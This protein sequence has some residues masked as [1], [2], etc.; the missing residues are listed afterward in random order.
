MGESSVG[1][2]GVSISNTGS[3]GAVAHWYPTVQSRMR[4]NTRNAP[5][6]PGCLCPVPVKTWCDTA[7]WRRAE[8]SALLEAGWVAREAV[9]CAPSPGPA[10]HWE[11]LRGGPKTCAQLGVTAPSPFS[12]TGDLTALWYR[13][14]LFK[15]C[16]LG[17]FPAMEEL[18]GGPQL[19]VPR[20]FSSHRTRGALPRMQRTHLPSRPSRRSAPPSQSCSLPAMSACALTPPTGTAVSTQ[21]GS[22]GAAVQAPS[23]S[24]TFP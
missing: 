3:S 18:V 23:H 8:S 16:F 11:L 6:K 14:S 22:W 17:R 4:D 5:G 21:R 1:L 20:H 7:G 15:M 12:S 24:G 19:F 2:E 9:P 10:Q 13:V